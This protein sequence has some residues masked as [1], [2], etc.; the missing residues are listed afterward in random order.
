MWVDGLALAPQQF[1]SVNTVVGP[2]LLPLN[3]V[4]H[5]GFVFF[6]GGMFGMEMTF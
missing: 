5:N 1:N 2:N 3:D 6:Q 4:D